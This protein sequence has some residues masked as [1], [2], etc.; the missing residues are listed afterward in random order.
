MCSQRA[1][2]VTKHPT[3]RRQQGGGAVVECIENS[4]CADVGQKA[5]EGAQHLRSI[6]SHAVTRAHDCKHAP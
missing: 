3:R 2:S 6:C 4:T 5:I 1:I